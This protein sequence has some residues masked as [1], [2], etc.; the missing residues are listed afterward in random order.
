[1]S[2][3]M[4]LGYSLQACVC[5]SLQLLRS[6]QRHTVV[7]GSRESYSVDL[8]LESLLQGPVRIVAWVQS[9]VCRRQMFTWKIE[10]VQRTV[11]TPRKFIPVRS[12]QTAL[13]QTSVTSSG[14][15]CDLRHLG[16]GWY[17]RESWKARAYWWSCLPDHRYIQHGMTWTYSKWWGPEDLPGHVGI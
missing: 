5:V 9:I 4:A 2:L 12:W 10:W 8:F 6:K 1:M 7:R 14:A 13:V 3:A 17:M 11:V 16:W 15:H